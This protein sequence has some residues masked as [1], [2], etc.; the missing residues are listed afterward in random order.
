MTPHSL[1]PHHLAFIDGM[2]VGRLATLGDDG[3]PSLVPICFAIVATDTPSI[4][5]VLD[6]KPKHVPDAE[7]ARV[8]NIRRDPRVSLIVDR[9]D[10]NWSQLAFVQIKGRARVVPP[11]EDGHAGAIAAL[12]EKYAQYRSM[13]IERR[14]VI[15]I[16]PHRTRSWGL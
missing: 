2:R 9:Y 14:A 15:V 8:R 6:E 1:L 5:S 10:E 4:V 16:E 7:L 13:G 12:R 11:G 3:T